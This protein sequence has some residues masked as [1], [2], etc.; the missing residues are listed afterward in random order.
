M[1][2]SRNSTTFAGPPLG[3]VLMVLILAGGLVPL[4]GCL[5]FSSFRLRPNSQAA[6]PR[7]R[8]SADPQME[9]VVDHLNQNVAKLHAW[10]ARRVSIRANGIPGLH[11]ILSVE[12][13]QHLRLSVSSMMGQEV[14]LGSNDDVFWINAR[15]MD[16]SYVYCHHDQIEDARQSLGIPFEPKWLMQ[17]LGVAP[18]DTADLKMQIDHSGQNARLVQPLLTVHGLPLQKVMQ[19]DLVK[20]VI[21]EHSIYDS[22][23]NKI[24]QAR[25]EDFRM[26]KTSGAVLPRRVLLDCPQSQLSLV[27]NMGDVEVNPRSI[28]EKIWEMP[29]AAPGIQVVDLGKEA[30]PLRMVAENSNDSAVQLQGFEE[31]PADDDSGRVRL[32]L[33]TTEVAEVEPEV[34][35]NRPLRVAQHAQP[36]AQMPTEPTAEP[37]E[38]PAKPRQRTAPVPGN[39]PAEQ[40]NGINWWDK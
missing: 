34:P 28:P 39:Q 21:T 6:I 24:A 9:E 23:G 11:G 5:G 26:D 18:I 20:G 3:R 29:P 25:L 37:D 40:S 13:G 33:D 7:P 2:S 4:Q 19:V 27:M 15:R 8:F 17:A 16:P 22:L 10:Q 1:P 31:L 35:F 32:E 12:E 38:W 36:G 14:D 30:R